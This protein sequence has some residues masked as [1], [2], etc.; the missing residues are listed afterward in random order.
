MENC[1]LCNKVLTEGGCDVHNLN[2]SYEMPMKITWDGKNCSL[3]NRV[4]NRICEKC[5]GKI[6]NAVN[7]CINGD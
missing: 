1:S 3:D 7:S 5:L 6:M 4:V 2:R